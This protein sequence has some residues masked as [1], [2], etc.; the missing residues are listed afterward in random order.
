M[1]WLA[2][3]DAL[4]GSTF[5]RDRRQSAAAKRTILNGETPATSSGFI[6]PSYFASMAVPMIP[7]SSEAA[8]RP[9]TTECTLASRCLGSLRLKSWDKNPQIASTVSVRPP[10]PRILAWAFRRMCRMHFRAH[11]D[12]SPGF[13]CERSCSRDRV[14]GAACFSSHVGPRL[15]RYTTYA[16]ATP[17]RDS[18]DGALRKHVARTPTTSSGLGLFEVFVPC[19]V[20][21]AWQLD[22]S[23]PSTRARARRRLYVADSSALMHVDTVE[24]RSVVWTRLQLST[25]ASAASAEATRTSGT[26]SSIPALTHLCASLLPEPKARKMARRVCCTPMRI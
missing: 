8:F 7:T 14:T 1:H 2:R 13:S 10:S 22:N 20:S 4:D 12:D 3:N 26:R 11:T 15:T 25:S 24:S 18:L 17:T 19:Q 9:Q 16:W 21:S 6:T 5:P 23:V